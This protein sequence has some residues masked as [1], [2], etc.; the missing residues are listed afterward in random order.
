MVV[1]TVIQGTLPSITH[2]P[3]GMKEGRNLEEKVISPGVN[4]VRKGIILK[5]RA[6]ELVEEKE[7]LK[8][9]AWL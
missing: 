4:A 7:K 5:S 8:E 6:V 1:R 2:G 3:N 9:Y